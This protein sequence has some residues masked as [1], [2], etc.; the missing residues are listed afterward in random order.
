MD[1]LSWTKTLRSIY[2]KAL[3]LYQLG[4]RD[5]EKFFTP[6]EK[7]FLASVG[8]KPIHVFDFVE[9]FAGEG[10]PDWETFLLIAAARRDY[11]LYAQKGQFNE[12]EM[13]SSELPPRREELGGIEWLPR[14]IMKARCFLEG[15]L[16]HDIMYCCG[17]D[18]NFLRTHN[19]HPAD[20]LREVWASHGDNQKVLDFVRAAP[21]A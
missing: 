10:V 15:G 17:G 7:Q 6:G 20:F 13:D 9:D 1:N 8:L 4:H 5:S 18:R 14:I 21:K 16:C 3:S 19:I 11:F 12:R 2:D